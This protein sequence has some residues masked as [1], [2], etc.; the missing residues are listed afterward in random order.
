MAE[1]FYNDED[2]V[3]VG[4]EWVEKLK[5]AAAASPLR[6]SRLRL[7]IDNSDAVQEMVIALCRDARFRPHRHQGKSES[8]HMIEG[9]L[10]VLVFDD[11]GRV[12][13]TV[14]MGPP[15]SGRQYCYRL[16]RPTWHAIVPISEL[17]VFHET[18]AGPFVQGD[19]AQ[20]A[21]WAPA[22]GSALGAFLDASLAAGVALEPREA[23]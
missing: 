4:A 16:C 6:R 2:I 23:A 9:D 21:D 7:H 22:G 20:F 1:V 8:F 17:V 10:Y 18:T 3:C 19:A 12:I 11:T 5:S 14:H 15:G 13:R